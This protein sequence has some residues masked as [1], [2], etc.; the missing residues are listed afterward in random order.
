MSCDIYVS[1]GAAHVVIFIEMQSYSARHV[2]SPS[3]SAMIFHLLPSVVLN[4]LQVEANVS[5]AVD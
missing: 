2:F 1:F 4:L 3:V 5:T